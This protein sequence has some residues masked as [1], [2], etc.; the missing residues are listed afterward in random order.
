MTDWIDTLSDTI[1]HA[2]DFVSHGRTPR[3]IVGVI[4]ASVL[5]F[6]IIAASITLTLG[7]DLPAGG[8]YV[9]GPLAIISFAATIYGFLPQGST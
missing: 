4:A 7:N 6:L 9:V 3:Q 8:W 2:A 5:L 1:F